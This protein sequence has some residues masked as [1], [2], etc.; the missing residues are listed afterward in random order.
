M[1]EVAEHP[2]MTNSHVLIERAI[3][4]GIAADELNKLLDFAERCERNAAVKAF[5][6][7]MNKCQ[8]EMPVVVRCKNNTATGSKYAPLEAVNE[9]IKE[10]YTRNGF[11]LSFSEEPCDKPDIV[12]VVCQVMHSAGHVVLHKGEYGLDVAGMKGTA[13]KTPVQGRVSTMTYGK[14]DLTCAIFNV[15]IADT[16]TDGNAV[17]PMLNDKQLAEIKGMIDECLLAGTGDFVPAF[18]KWLNV[19]SVDYLRQT[20]FGLAMNELYRKKSAAIKAKGK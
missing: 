5:N 10:T 11:S 15:V 16:D 2:A 6:I 3:E 8:A 7:A 17:D 19:P 9:R 14:R 13:N 4:K 1:N 20:Q 18:L 12:R